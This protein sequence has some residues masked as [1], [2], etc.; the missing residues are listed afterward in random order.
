MIM[1]HNSFV[2]ITIMVFSFGIH[3]DT[4]YNTFVLIF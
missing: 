3:G 2:L 4:D 1:T